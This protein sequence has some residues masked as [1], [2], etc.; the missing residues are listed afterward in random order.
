MCKISN[1]KKKHFRS[2]SAEISNKLSLS[3]QKAKQKYFFFQPLRGIKAANDF[4]FLLKTSLLKEQ[5]IAINEKGSKRILKVGKR[6]KVA[7][8]KN[9]FYYNFCESS[10]LCGCG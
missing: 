2:E 4:F 10:L 1:K 6:R 9:I 3:S 5:K 8:K 7:K